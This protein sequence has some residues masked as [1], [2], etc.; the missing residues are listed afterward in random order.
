MSKRSQGDLEDTHD[1][2]AAEFHRVY[3][4]HGAESVYNVDETDGRVWKSYLRTI[5]H[6]DIEEASVILVDNF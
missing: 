6:D 3:R 4:A 1:I 2:F 5:L